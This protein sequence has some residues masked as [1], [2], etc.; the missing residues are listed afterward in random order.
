ML[1]RRD[2]AIREGKRACELLPYSRDSWV[3]PQLINN[4]A[5]IYAWV[6]DN[7]SALKQLEVSVNIP[8]GISYG[9]LKLNPD[10]D[11]LR[12]DPR[13]EK[14]VASRAPKESAG[15]SK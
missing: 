3:G 11:P 2:D 4:L 13:F 1:G 10:W 12:G 9:E 15:T 8:T 14:I 6:G 5:M 7:E